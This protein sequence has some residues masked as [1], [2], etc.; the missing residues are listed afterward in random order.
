MPSSVKLTLTAPQL[1]KHSL[2]K[3]FQL[4]HKQLNGEST[5]KHEIELNIDDGEVQ[6]LLNNIQIGKGFKFKP[7]MEGGSIEPQIFYAGGDKL[8][9][10]QKEKL[11]RALKGSD[12]ALAWGAK[13]KQLRLAKQSGVVDEEIV[14]GST[15][16]ERQNRRIKNTFKDIGR[17]L[18]PAVPV[19]KQ[20]GQ[21]ALP[22]VKDV[23]KTVGTKLLTEAMIGGST[24]NQRLKRR[25]KTTFKDIGRV[26]A[27]AVPVL[28][29]VVLPIVKDVGATMLKSAIMGGDLITPYSNLIGGVRRPVYTKKHMDSINT[30]GLGYKQAGVNGIIKGGSFLPL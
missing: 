30:L 4:S 5:G 24:Y 11:G 21:V 7:P 3:A 29:D 1:K 20:I 13:M 15:Y 23:A 17:V 18:K 14:G 10:Q 9:R 12:E 26:L 27:P 8:R 28:K 22:I 6:R 19:L 16:M 25:V 2:G